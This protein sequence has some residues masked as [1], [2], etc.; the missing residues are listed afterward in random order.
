MLGSDA[1]LSHCGSHCHVHWHA[2]RVSS[3]ARGRSRLLERHARFTPWT[4]P[5]LVE[6][7]Y[8]RAIRV[9]PGTGGLSVKRCR[10]RNF[11]SL[12]HTEES[13]VVIVGGGPAGLAL[14]S[15]LGMSGF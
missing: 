1:R 15:A 9:T 10:R 8:R 14:A 2:R 11:A 12:A 5:A 13:D 7:M 3:L 6:V 4:C